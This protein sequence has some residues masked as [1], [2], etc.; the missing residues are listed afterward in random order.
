MRLTRLG[1]ALLLTQIGAGALL[2]QEFTSVSGG[3]VELLTKGQKRLSGSLGVTRSSQALNGYEAT[4]GGTILEDRIWFFA[5]ASMLPTVSMSSNV[6][7]IDAKLDA[8]LGSRNTLG[9]SFSQQDQQFVT[10]STAPTIT[11]SSFLSL[12][13]TSVISDNIFFN[14]SFLR[15]S[16]KGTDLLRRE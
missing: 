10:S 6:G 12:R 2:A 15:S 4:L 1:V 3:E 11:P 7:A 8:Q 16:S 13:Y 9:A 5:A 14:A